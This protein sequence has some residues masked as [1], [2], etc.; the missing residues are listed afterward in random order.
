MS[1]R[2]IAYLIKYLSQARSRQHLLLFSL[3]GP[4]L[5]SF[6]LLVVQSTMGGLQHNLVYRSKNIS[7]DYLLILPPGQDFNLERIWNISQ[8]LKISIIPEREEEVLLRNGPYMAPAILRGIPDSIP[9][10]LLPHSLKG[11]KFDGLIMGSDLA[12]KLRARPHSD[13]VIITPSKTDL[14]FDEIPRYVTERLNEIVLTDVPEIDAIQVWSRDRLVWNLIKQKNYNQM[15]VYFNDQANIK[16]EKVI[17]KLDQEGVKIQ[18]VLSW[19]EQNDALAGALKL[20]SKVMLFLF[21]CISLLV[22]L[23]MASG[24]IVF[25]NKINLDLVGLWIL[26]MSK[27]SILKHIL[28]LT[29]MIIISSI[30]SGVILGTLFLYLLESEGGE[31]LPSIFVDRKIPVLFSNGTYLLAIFIPLIIASFLIPLAL[32]QFRN[33]SNFLEIIRG[34]SL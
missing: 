16:I 30:G 3:L 19:E 7:G 10:N 15:R 18:K 29:F 26:G 20:E 22:T 4:F 13:L 24:L 34:K 32:R 21:S 11:Q 12:V 31:I 1:F 14:S 2:F 9:K 27:N 8:E 23:S 17:E 28:I 6:S 25:F 5:A 33:Q